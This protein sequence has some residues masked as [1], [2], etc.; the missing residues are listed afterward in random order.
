ML[1]QLA[2]IDPKYIKKTYKKIDIK[3]K[4][5]KKKKRNKKGTKDS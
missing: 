3:N 1:K 5:K 2:I 4:N